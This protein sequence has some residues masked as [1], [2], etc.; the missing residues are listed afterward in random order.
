MLSLSVGGTMVMRRYQ[1]PIAVGFFLGVV[2]IMSN[3]CLILTAVFG[4]ES[5][6]K[7]LNPDGDPAS[8]A[9][10][11]FSFFLFVVYAVFAGMLAVFRD[12]LIH[13]HGD[14]GS[15]D[16]GIDVEQPGDGNEGETKAQGMDNGGN[17]NS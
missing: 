5:S 4:E 8:G 2:V 1:T 17:V 7:S 16:K 9:F 6:N 12:D 3:Q 11:T 10:A 15:F 13:D 14:A